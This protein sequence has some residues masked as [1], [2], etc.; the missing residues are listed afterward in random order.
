MKNDAGEMSLS[1]DSKQ[2]LV[3]AL[4]KVSQCLV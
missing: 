4:P 3:R 2:G 1:E